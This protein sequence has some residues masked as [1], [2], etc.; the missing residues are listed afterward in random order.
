ML[1]MCVLI[2]MMS[3]HGSLDKYVSEILMDSGNVLCVSAETIKELIVNYNNKTLLSSMWR[4]CHEMVSY[5][6]D[7]MSIKVLPID[8]NVLNTYSSLDLNLQNNH[9]DPSDHII[10]SHAITA[11]IPLISSDRKFEFYKSQ[12]LDLI[13]NNK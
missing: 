13:F 8:K 10:I 11:K 1:D 2:Y 12:G 7:D 6:L 4:T 5:I 9:K 3:D